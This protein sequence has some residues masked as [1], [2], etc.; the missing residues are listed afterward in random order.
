MK[1][2]KWVEFSK[3]VEVSISLEDVRECLIEAADN[4]LPE[5]FRIL[6]DLGVIFKG[7]PDEMIAKLNPQQRETILKFLHEQQ[8][9]FSTVST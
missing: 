3:E 4:S 8:R 6:N 2:S 5:L 9:R 1:I 7:V